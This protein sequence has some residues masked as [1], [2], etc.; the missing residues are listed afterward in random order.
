MGWIETTGDQ[1]NVGDII[2]H[3][4]VHGRIKFI[5]AAFGPHRG[6][7]RVGVE[8]SPDLFIDPDEVVEV[9]R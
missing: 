9:F 2:S 6:K 1:L 7:Y 4:K 5:E 3:Y 8:Q